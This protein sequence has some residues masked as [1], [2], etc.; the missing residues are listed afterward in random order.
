M[1]QAPPCW[2]SEELTCILKNLRTEFQHSKMSVAVCEDGRKSSVDVLHCALARWQVVWELFLS[3]PS[4]GTVLSRSSG[5]SCLAIAVSSTEALECWHLS[6]WDTWLGKAVQLCYH[7]LLLENHS[8]L[9]TSSSEHF[10]RDGQN[11]VQFHASIFSL[12]FFSP[13]SL[14][15]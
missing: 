10:S 15:I 3:C 4:C 8:L 12:V 14:L 7:H 9:S 13:C 5:C 1:L 6:R 11:Q 2:H